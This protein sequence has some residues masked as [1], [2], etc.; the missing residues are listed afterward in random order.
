MGNGFKLT[1]QTVEEKLNYLNSQIGSTFKLDKRNTDNP[2]VVEY[3]VF[4]NGRLFKAGSLSNIDSYIDGIYV[5][6]GLP[7]SNGVSQNKTV[8]H[9]NDNPHP[10]AVPLSNGGY[11]DNPIKTFLKSRQNRGHWNKFSI[12]GKKKAK[13][14]EWSDNG[15]MYE[16]EVMEYTGDCI[17]F[18]VEFTWMAPNQT[19]PGNIYAYS[20]LTLNVTPSMSLNDMAYGIT[21]LCDEAYVEEAM[22]NG[23]N[24]FASRYILTVTP[25]LPDKLGFYEGAVTTNSYAKIVS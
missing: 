16:V 3:G 18:S 12:V 9:T 15:I 25:D 11:K 8:G 22:L 10:S 6:V 5:G 20:G 23:P 7:K 1:A 2:S 24:R 17:V 4:C 13:D 19:L 14:P 21:K